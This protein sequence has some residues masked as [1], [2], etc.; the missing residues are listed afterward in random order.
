V[1]L[2]RSLFPVTRA[3]SGSK[4]I[5]SIE[6]AGT[7]ERSR[8]VTTSPTANEVRLVKNSPATGT[9]DWTDRP[10]STGTRYGSMSSSSSRMTTSSRRLVTLASNDTGAPDSVRAQMR[11]RPIARATNLPSGSTST[12]SGESEQK[13]ASCTDAFLRTNAAASRASPTPTRINVGS[14][15]VEVREDRSGSCG[16]C[17]PD[18]DS[19]LSRR[20]LEP[21]SPSTMKRQA[22]TRRRLSA[23]PWPRSLLKADLPGP[24]DRRCRESRCGGV[25]RH[26]P[27]G[28]GP[29]RGRRRPGSAR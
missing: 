23:R 21:T 2:R 20:Q 24:S 25:G 28:P 22:R 17:A 29:R 6:S 4:V 27:T 14:I 15:K 12:T 16:C 8:V 1:I 10:A 11:D 18:T 13:D 3:L 26:R 19:R 7:V 5:S 9:I